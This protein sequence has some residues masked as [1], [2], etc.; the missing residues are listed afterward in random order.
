MAAASSLRQS[1]LA[2]CSWFLELGCC[3][4]ICDGHKRFL[5]AV[6]QKW[7]FAVLEHRMIMVKPI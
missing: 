1:F 4:A 5:E 7:L 6:G 2:G 3:Q